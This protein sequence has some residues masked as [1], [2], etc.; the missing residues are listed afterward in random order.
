MRD[1]PDAVLIT[2]D[3]LHEAETAYVAH[4]SKNVFFNRQIF[5]DAYCKQECS[6]CYLTPPQKESTPMHA[7]RSLHS[8]LAEAY[9]C[10]Q[11]G[12]KIS[13]IGDARS[14]SISD[15]IEMCKHVAIITGERPWLNAGILSHNDLDLLK[16]Y[17]EGVLAPIETA[18]RQVYKEICPKKSITPLIT[19]LNETPTKR[20][21]NIILGVGERLP[22]IDDLFA[23]MKNNQIRRV[24]FQIPTVRREGSES[25]SSFYIA[26]WI[27]E[28]RI[29]FP[30]CE[31]IAATHFSRAAEV[32]LF[33]KAGANEITGFP[34]V[35]LFNSEAAK[36][37][38]QEAQNAGR[39]LMSNLTEINALRTLTQVN[40]DQEIKE[41]LEKYKQILER[42]K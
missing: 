15:L 37:I 31:I 21:I 13:L 26:R 8:L 29:A 9:L 25:P 32:S 3:L 11:L 12:W 28:T 23:F 38:T 42:E 6:M 10:R 16:P 20:G 39:F 7:P 19:M 35:S 5:F 34:A 17:I 4:W 2:E 1:H 22:D 40:A 24:M 36:I 18:N 14:H 33:L 30:N 27:A 41:K